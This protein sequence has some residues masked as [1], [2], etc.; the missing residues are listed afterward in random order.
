MTHKLLPLGDGTG[1]GF[2]DLFWHAFGKFDG[3]GHGHGESAA[4]GHH[5]IDGGG[6]SDAACMTVVAGF[7]PKNNG[8]VVDGAGYSDYGLILSAG[9]GDGAG[10]GGSGCLDGHGF[11]VA[12]YAYG[13]GDG[14]GDGDGGGDYMTT[15]QTVRR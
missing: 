7:G 1:A 9:D 6:F 4:Y 5:F 3:S 2:G 11:S 13:K 14:D 15:W 10:V 12:G 8:H